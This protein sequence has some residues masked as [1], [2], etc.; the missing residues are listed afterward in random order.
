MAAQSSVNRIAGEENS[1]AERTWGEEAAQERA[2]VC[3]CV[4]LRE[5]G[6]PLCRT[7]PSMFFL[8]GVSLCGR[9]PLGLHP[10]S[11]LLRAWAGSG[12]GQHVTSCHFRGGESLGDISIFLL[13]MV[14]NRH[15]HSRKIRKLA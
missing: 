4:R 8:E 3:E 9:L 6:T 1:Q 11:P 14:F 12:L 15:H 10:C 13:L 2:C 7:C 5:M